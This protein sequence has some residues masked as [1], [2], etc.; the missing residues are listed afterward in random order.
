MILKPISEGR[1]VASLVAYLTHDQVSA[2]D[3][4]PTTDERV[5]WTATLGGS[6]TADIDLCVRMM[7]GRVAD[8]PLL[9]QRAGVSARGRKLRNPYAHF[10]A[11]WPPGQ[12]PTR[13][14][15]LELADRAL[16]ALGL[17]DHLAVLVAHNDTDHAHWHLVVCKVH[18]ETGKAA[19]LGRS[20]LR[21]SKVAEQWE[22]EHCGIV[23]DNRVRRREARER[24]AE[25]VAGRMSDFKDRRETTP[26]AQAERRAAELD[27]ARRRA[28]DLHPLPPAERSR[29]P[30][31]R[32]RTDGEREDWAQVYEQERRTPT[33]PP[34]TRTERFRQRLQRRLRKA[35]ESRD[36]ARAIAERLVPRPRGRHGIV[37]R[38]W[39]RLAAAV[40]R[41]VDRFAARQALD[42]RLADARIE[43][44]LGSRRRLGNAIDTAMDAILSARRTGTP[45]T[46]MD[47]YR[48][49][50]N[51]ARRRLDRY[52]RSVEPAVRD[53]DAAVRREALTRERQH[54]REHEWQRRK[55][56]RA[57]AARGRQQPGRAAE[58]T[59][60]A[61]ERRSPPRAAPAPAPAAPRPAPYQVPENP[62]T[63]PSP[64]RDAG[65]TADRSRGQDRDWRR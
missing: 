52:E 63:P 12:A 49:R 5:A 44:V 65:E 55:R 9:K 58:P 39:A 27:A 40:R 11:A 53:H 28:R 43:R 64:A 45:A 1:G 20:G 21:L 42:A 2:D 51:R 30:G 37:R 41:P 22:R 26:Q 15:Q 48:E 14:E 19:S 4:R 50:H 57:E 60:P 59:S 6:P 23:I 32:P 35:G 3:P 24:Y 18:P 31:R 8:A 10:T 7:Q 33:P 13:D 61:A 46:Q 29:G 36:R 17:E 25:Y 34:Q 16:S 47:R 62:P 54:E 38:T 56:E